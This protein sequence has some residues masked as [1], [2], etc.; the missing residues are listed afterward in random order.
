MEPVVVVADGS[1]WTEEALQW[2]TAHA[3]L[4]DAEVEIHQPE[5]DFH[6]QLVVL[7]YQGRTGSPLG[8]G[9]HVLS[10]VCAAGRDA[11]VVRGTPDARH[12][13]HGR[14][15]A[16]VSGGADD[17]GVLARAAVFAQS[18]GAALR[19]LHA[20][21]PSVLREDLDADR[22][23][24]LDRSAELLA[25]FPHT[26]VLVRRQP[27]EAISRSF[28][29]DLLVVGSGETRSCG[30]VTRAAL[31]HAPCPVLVAHRPVQEEHRGVSSLPAPRR[32]VRAT[33]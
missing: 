19:V 25:G 12:G 24:V 9:S 29:T 21:P 18:R 10:I 14:V 5:D 30:A 11:V 27:H 4:I 7:G 16:L 6:A 31:H 1:P 2:A 17:A 33:V 26:A 13:L 20:A 28:G 22:S 23:W 15:T 3:K 32:P 8:L